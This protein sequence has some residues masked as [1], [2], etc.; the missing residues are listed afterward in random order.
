MSHSDGTEKRIEAGFTR[1]SLVFTGETLPEGA[2]ADGVY[3]ILNDPYRD[4]LNT[5]PVRPLN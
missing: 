2:V 1:Y 5:A 4:V 3:I